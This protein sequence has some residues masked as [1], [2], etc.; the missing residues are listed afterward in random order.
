ME[1]LPRKIAC[2]F[3][4]VNRDQEYFGPTKP[5]AYIA[6]RGVTYLGLLHCEPE[7]RYCALHVNQTFCE[8]RSLELQALSEAQ[9]RGYQIFWKLTCFHCG[10]DI[11]SGDDR[12][13]GCLRCLCDLCPRRNQVRFERLGPLKV[14]SVPIVDTFS[15]V[16]G[17]LWIEEGR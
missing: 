1:I 10:S 16:K 17:K 7:E 9:P 14:G 6:G 4:K 12:S 2:A 5:R 15:Y 11:Q 8:Y 3:W 13:T